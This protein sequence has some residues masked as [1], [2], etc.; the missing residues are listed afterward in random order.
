[1]VQNVIIE[2]A[3]L[4]I[5][6]NFTSSITLETVAR[7]VGISKFHFHRMFKHELNETLNDY[8]HRLR[9]EKAIHL[10]QMYPTISSIEVAFQCGYSS[11]NEFSRVFKKHYSC[12]FRDYRKAKFSTPITSVSSSQ[13]RIPVVYLRKVKLNVKSAYLIKSQLDQLF[14]SLD[15]IVPNGGLIYGVFVDA[16]MHIALE[17]CRYFAGVEIN[18]ETE[19]KSNFEIDE[20]YYTYLD[21]VGSNSDLI[22][23]IRKFKEEQIDPSAYEIASFIGFEKIDYNNVDYYS[24]NRT[25]YIKIR[26]KSARFE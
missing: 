22:Q 14:Q 13:N 18:R 3:I 9:M 26:K 20:G 10:F 12:S 24:S 7:E 15:E 21:F 23:K 5:A 4:F 17:K 16:P 11:P 2:K 19:I 1:M 8:I 6:Q 25:I